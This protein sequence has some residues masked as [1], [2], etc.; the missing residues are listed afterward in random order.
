MVKADW[1]SAQYGRFLDERTRPA[2]DLLAQVAVDGRGP[3]VD[4]G[5]GPGNST[6]ALLQRWPDAEVDAWRVGMSFTELGEN[7]L[8]VWA[9]ESVVVGERE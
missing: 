3:L 7:P 4:V 5:C 1:S 9:D 8:G 2:R 6:A